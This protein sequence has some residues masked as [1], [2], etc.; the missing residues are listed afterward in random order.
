[1]APPRWVQQST[2][3]TDASGAFSFTGVA[4]GTIGDV[5][6]LQV[7]NDGTGT[8]SWGTLSGT[9][10]EALDGT[11]NTWTEIGIFFAGAAAQQRLFIG[12]RT[13]ASAAPTFTASANTS[14]NDVYG[15]MHEFTD[16][17]AGTT[18]AEVIENGTAGG[19]STSGVTSS[20]TASDAAV[21][22]LGPDRLALNFEAVNDDNSLATFTGM[23]GGHWIAF[24]SLYA[25]SGGTDG[26]L[27]LQAAPMLSDIQAFASTVGAAIGS[28]STEEA[29]AQSFT[30]PS[31]VS[32]SGVGFYC[33]KNGSPTDD[34]VVE[35]RAGSQTGSVV[36]SGSISASSLPALSLRL[37]YVPLSATL[38]SG[39]TYFLVLTRSGSLDA[40]NYVSGRRSTVSAYAGGIASKRASGTWSDIAD[41]DLCFGISYS[42]FT[43]ATIDGGTGSITDIDSWGVVGFALIGTSAA[44]PV[45]YVPRHS[46]HDFGSVTNF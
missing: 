26:A 16:V 19:T 40:S 5:V 46:A 44:P 35:I 38:N 13:S 18:L 43:G 12:R 30:V 27:L 41:A 8:I 23:T 36:A 11:V 10:I 45:V 21:T 22:T 14:G 4:T 42:G 6:I 3:D 37:Q 20:A 1:M 33:A 2:G 31:T 25:D 28:D 39:T 34:V 32:V 9:N 24:G 15:L 7:L 17:S 29:V